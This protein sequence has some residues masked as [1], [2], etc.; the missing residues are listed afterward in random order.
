MLVKIDYVVLVGNPIDLQYEPDEVT[1]LYPITKSIK[2]EG[3][4]WGGKGLEG[5]VQI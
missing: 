1:R 3:W 4:K 5:K 2:N